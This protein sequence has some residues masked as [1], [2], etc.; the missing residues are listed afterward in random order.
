MPVQIPS[1]R[2]MIP[3]EIEFGQRILQEA[4]KPERETFLLIHPAEFILQV[5]FM[6][7]LISIPVQVHFL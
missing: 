3:M 1:L 6:E 7:H 4:E 2:V 5:I